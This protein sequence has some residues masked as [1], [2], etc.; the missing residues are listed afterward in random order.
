MSTY[1]QIIYQIVFGTYKHER[2]MQGD[3]K[4]ELYKYITGILT[5]K[6]CHLYRING[7]EEHLHIVTHLHPSVALANLVKD[8]K[9]ASSKWIKENKIFSQFNDWQDGYGAFTYTIKEKDR[10]I[11]YVKNQQA[12]HKIK[13]FREE[14]I[15]LLKEN[16]VEYD[17]KYIL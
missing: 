17:E 12:H 5:N 7:M 2:T 11:E 8:I 3:R 1:T 6:K 15:E 9:L 4:E 13:T 10:L 14:Y 16:G